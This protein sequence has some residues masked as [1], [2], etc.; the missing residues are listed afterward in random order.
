VFDI[1][2]DDRSGT[3]W[4]EGDFLATF[5][6]EGIHFFFHDIR[7][8]ADT[9]FEQVGVFKNRRP[10]FLEAIAGK[11]LVS[12]GLHPLPLFNFSRQDVLN[13]FDAFDFHT[14]VLWVIS[15]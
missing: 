3:F 5:I 8:V 4:P 11:Y 2:P 9:S 7:G 1:G 10:N 13:A 6:C 15:F 14:E 12:D